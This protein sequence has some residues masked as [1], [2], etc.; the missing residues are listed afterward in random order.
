MGHVC[1]DWRFDCDLLF[2][3]RVG[4]RN[5]L[6]VK[7]MSLQEAIVVLRLARDPEICRAETRAL[8]I[9]PVAGDW[10]AD[11]TQVDPNL[12]SAAGFGFNS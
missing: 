2:C 12:V 1:G 5:G 7:C 6:G 4:K 10:V 8:A 3:S 11:V 9:Y